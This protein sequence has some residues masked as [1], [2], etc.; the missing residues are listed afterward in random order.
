MDVF[1]AADTLCPMDRGGQLGAS[2]SAGD[3]YRMVSEVVSGLLC[4]QRDV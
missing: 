4:G 1:S 3:F 2:G